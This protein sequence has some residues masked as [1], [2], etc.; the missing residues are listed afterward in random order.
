MKNKTQFHLIKNHQ[1][2]KKKKYHLPLLVPALIY[3]HFSVDAFNDKTQQSSK[4]TIQISSKMIQQILPT[5][6][7]SSKNDSNDSTNSIT[8]ITTMIKV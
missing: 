3:F 8:T 7:V 2:H 1:R 6:L 4:T 5:I